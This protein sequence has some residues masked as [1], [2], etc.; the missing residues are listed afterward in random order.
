MMKQVL[1]SKKF[2]L[3]LDDVKDKNQIN[4][5]VL[6]DV[7]HFNKGGQKRLKCWK[8]A[9]QKLRRR[10]PLDGDEIDSEYKLWTILKISFDTLKVKE[11]NLFLDI[12]CFFCNN[13]K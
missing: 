10:R 8:R 11:K 7:L 5:V 12:C 2:M 3:V 9:L 1:M 6:L 4:D 13:V